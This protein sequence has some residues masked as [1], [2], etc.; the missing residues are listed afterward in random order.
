MKYVPCMLSYN[1]VFLLVV[2]IGCALVSFSKMS[3]YALTA[4]WVSFLGLTGTYKLGW[5]IVVIKV[6]SLNWALS[7]ISPKKNFKSEEVE[8]WIWNFNEKVLI[9]RFWKWRFLLRSLWVSKE[10]KCFDKFT[11]FP[12]ELDLYLSAFAIAR[13]SLKVFHEQNS[14]TLTD[15]IGLVMTFWGGGYLDFFRLGMFFLNLSIF[16]L[17]L[18]TMLSLIFY[19][20]NFRLHWAVFDSSVHFHRLLC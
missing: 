15:Q 11:A 6:S 1:W 12:D 3:V 2:S 18:H 20:D 17:P 7:L 5:F 4:W 16:T 8:R 9:M 10:N 19:K 13:C 14:A